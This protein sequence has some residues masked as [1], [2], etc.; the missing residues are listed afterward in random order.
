MRQE[1]I[2]KRKEE[3]NEKDIKEVGKKKNIKQDNINYD[4]DGNSMSMKPEK[5]K[6]LISKIVEGKL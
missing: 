3:A 1:T 4:Y 6:N 2:R 5:R